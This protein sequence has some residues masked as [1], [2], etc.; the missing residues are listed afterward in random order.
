MKP[1][2]IFEKIKIGILFPGL[3]FLSWQISPVLQSLFVEQPTIQRIRILIIS[4]WQQSLSLFMSISNHIMI[5]LQPVPL[6][7]HF[8]KRHISLRP[9]SLDI[10]HSTY[11]TKHYLWKDENKHTIPWFAFFILTDFSRFTILICWTT[12][13]LKNKNINKRVLRVNKVYSKTN[14]W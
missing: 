14:F 6:Q 9:Q 8:P 4:T 10:V 11:K 7:R 2:I 1:N 5:P 12:Y 3:H 13:S